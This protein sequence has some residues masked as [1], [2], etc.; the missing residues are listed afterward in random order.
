LQE[1]PAEFIKDDFL[2]IFL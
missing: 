1:I 2:N